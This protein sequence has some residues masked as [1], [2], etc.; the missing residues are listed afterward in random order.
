[1]LLLSFSINKDTTVCKVS[2]LFLYNFCNLLTNIM[3]CVL[4][5]FYITMTTVCMKMA[6]HF[7]IK[8]VHFTT[9]KYI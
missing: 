5:I 2:C 3:L 9:D 1:M 7:Y 4:T 8:V 6:K